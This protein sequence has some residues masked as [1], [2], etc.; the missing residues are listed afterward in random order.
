[1]GE[2]HLSLAYQQ[3]G[4]LFWATADKPNLPFYAAKDPSIMRWY[5]ED[6][7]LNVVCSDPLKSHEPIILIATYFQAPVLL[8]QGYIVA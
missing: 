4:M 8:K 3:G 7:V 2:V 6:Q 1:M 5:Q